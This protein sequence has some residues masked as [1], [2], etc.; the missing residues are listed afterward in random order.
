MKNIYAPRGTKVRFIGCIDA[1]QNWGGPYGDHNKF[2]V[3][4]KVYTI[5]YIIVKSWSTKVYL[6][7]FPVVSFNSVCFEEV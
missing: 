7:E 3:V 4:D 5:D 6:E 1:Q 2:L